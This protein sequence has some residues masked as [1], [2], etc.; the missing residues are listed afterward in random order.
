MRVFLYHQASGVVAD[1]S[2]R[3]RRAAVIVDGTDDLTASALDLEQ[4]NYDV[5]VLD[6][7]DP[8][9]L[10][11]F[12]DFRGRGEE[13]P[14][15]LICADVLGAFEKGADDCVGP[16]FAPDELVA[17]V[18]ALARL[19]A[20]PVGPVLEVGSVRLFPSR[21]EARRGDR[22]VSLT[23][24]E[25]ALLEVFLR[26]PG[27]VLDRS[28]LARHCWGDSA[29]VSDNRIAAQVH[30]LRRKLGPPE[31]LL[32]ARGRGYLLWLEP[33]V[34]AGGRRD[35]GSGRNGKGRP[36]QQAILEVLRRHG[37]PRT[38]DQVAAELER[39]GTTFE[40]GDPTDTVHAILLTLLRR[41]PV[42]RSGD[43]S[44]PRFKAADGA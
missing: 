13:T 9:A 43:K 29:R 8:A 11:M 41:G 7:T 6:A 23:A 22:I 18:V 16:E 25:C 10:A 27:E 33:E 34:V 21:L 38:S 20:L 39:H 30:A 32:S 35:P 1:M 4:A 12:E 36:L 3:F 5:V 17:R 44:R 2:R 24:K 31:I 26:Y 37:R 42:I 14:V 40:S 19:K 28:F 15:L